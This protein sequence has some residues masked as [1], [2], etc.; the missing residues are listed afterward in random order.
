MKIHL[1]KV[2][3]SKFKRVYASSSN[4]KVFEQRRKR[5]SKFTFEFKFKILHLSLDFKEEAKGK[6]K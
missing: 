4:I 2:I 3:L 6:T 1:N 5:W